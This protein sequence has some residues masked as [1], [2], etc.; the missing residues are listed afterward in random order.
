MKVTR[1]LWIV[2]SPLALQFKRA[3]VPCVRVAVKIEFRALGVHMAVYQDLLPH[4]A[5]CMHPHSQLAHEELRRRELPPRAC[6]YAPMPDPNLL[7]LYFVSAA[8]RLDLVSN[9]GTLKHQVYINPD[10]FC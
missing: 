4:P 1:L 9:T 2:K 7:Q 10:S 3:M 8:A 5:L 6:L